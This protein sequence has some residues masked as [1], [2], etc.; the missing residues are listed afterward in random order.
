MAGKGKTGP[1]PKSPKDIFD[2][3]TAQMDAQKGFKGSK[4]PA[5]A[6][7]E[8]SARTANEGDKGPYGRRVVSEMGGKN[9]GNNVQN[10]NDGT[11]SV[12]KKSRD[13][14]TEALPFTKVPRGLY[15]P[16]RGEGPP[17]NSNA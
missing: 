4:R 16:V 2:F 8:Y 3:E 1:F 15:H 13:H 9:E 5:K 6:F 17:G 11:M 10:V 12:P 7:G 14:M